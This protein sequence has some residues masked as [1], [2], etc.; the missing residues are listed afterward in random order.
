[1][2]KVGPSLSP[3]S[4]GRLP[5]DLMWG[6]EKVATCS[7]CQALPTSPLALPL[8]LNVPKG[9][10]PWR[11]TILTGPSQVKCYEPEMQGAP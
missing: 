8:D 11:L 1:M 7:C 6:G 5:V 9:S 4:S 10:C 2:T 3:L